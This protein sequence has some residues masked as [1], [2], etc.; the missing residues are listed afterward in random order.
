MHSPSVHRNVRAASGVAI[1]LRSAA[2]TLVEV[3]VAAGVSCIIGL[4]IYGVA[5]E[6]LLAFGRNISINRSYGEARRSLDRIGL[7]ME[8]AGHT[9]VLLD[10]T[11]ATTLS[12]PAA[13]IRFWRYSSSPCYTI[14]TP[15]MASTSI[16]VSLLQPGTS[17]R[18]PAPVPGDIITIAALGFQA[19]V[20]SPVSVGATTATVPFSGSLASNTS[21]VIT[22]IP[23]L[24]TGSTMSCLDWN[25]V[26]YIVVGNQLR[27]YS[28]FLS[29]V[30][31]VNTSFYEVIANVISTTPGKPFVLGS[32][33]T[34][35]TVTTS[36]ALPF[37]LGPS[38]S[39]NVNL[40]AEAPDYNNRN[41]GSANTYNY[42][43]AAF[44]PRNPALLH[45]PY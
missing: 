28:Q 16:T 36:P 13:G 12:S 14:T 23:T 29:G 22:A 10:A 18:L 31:N 11:G 41:L 24:P 26:A 3:M 17:A 34:T 19:Q 37:S 44:A 45:S 21:P 6:A 5:S 35:G 2:F 25:S 30:T 8:S 9:P 32:S 4:V 42:L 39:V 33:P 43:Q 20:T 7:A 15:T 27:Y 38:P 1:R 40:Y